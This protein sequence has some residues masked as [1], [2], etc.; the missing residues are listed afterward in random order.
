[1]GYNPAMWEKHLGDGARAYSFDSFS[2]HLY[3]IYVKVKLLDSLNVKIDNALLCI[4]T[5]YYFFYPERVKAEDVAITGWHHPIFSD[6]PEIENLKFQKN[7]FHFYLNSD[8][9]ASYYLN[10]FF[11]VDN[12]YT[13]RNLN[14]TDVTIDPGTN[15][16]SRPD[17]EKKI[18]ENN[19]DYSN[20]KYFPPQVDTTFVYPPAI[21]EK[22][23]GML[24]YIRQVF[25]KNDTDY[26]VI[27][28][29]LYDQRKFY[30]KDLDI[31]ENIFG[32]ENVYD[33]SGKNYFTR[34]KS[35]YYESSHFRPLVGDS[36]LNYI[37]QDK[38]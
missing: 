17:L 28:N 23:V 36:I 7:Y 32:K 10:K 14:M 12:E 34:S 26:K 6:N 5:E 27:I 1:M 3:G 19:Y 35:N 2:E 9:L 38:K 37:Y 30:A 31:L 29:P 15:W 21:G 22:A 8:F 11:G 4:D 18:K 25:D 20:P 33:F 16:I 13:E 24:K